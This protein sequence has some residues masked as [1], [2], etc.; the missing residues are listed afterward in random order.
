[1]I[2]HISCITGNVR[3]AGTDA[4]VFIQLKGTTG[5]SEVHRL[6]NSKAKKEFETGKID[7]FHVN[8]KQN[9]SRESIQNC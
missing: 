5:V 7:H 6:H 4:K 3:F 9:F 8:N 1:M 2:Y